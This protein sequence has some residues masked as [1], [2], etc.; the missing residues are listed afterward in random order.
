MN[1][2][3]NC[4]LKKSEKCLSERLINSANP[5]SDDIDKILIKKNMKLVIENM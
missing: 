1:L 3:R 2:L 4:N 5:S